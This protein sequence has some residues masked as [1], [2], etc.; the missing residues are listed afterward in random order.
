MLD[1]AQDIAIHDI[2]GRTYAFVAG[3]VGVQVIDITRPT[4]PQ[5]AAWLDGAENVVVHDISDRTYALVGDVHRG[6][7]IM[8]VTNLEPDP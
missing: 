4:D 1:E 6:V 7:N 5:P 3:D 2:S 8:D